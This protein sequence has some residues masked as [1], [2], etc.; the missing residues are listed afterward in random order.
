MCNNGNNG[1]ID[2][3]MND[4]QLINL[5]KKY[6]VRYVIRNF[7]LSENIISSIVK[8]EFSSLS[9]EDDIDISEI[10]KYQEALK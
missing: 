3:Y 10:R 2:N 6:G 4:G 5:I 9:E 1:H 7:K 8:N